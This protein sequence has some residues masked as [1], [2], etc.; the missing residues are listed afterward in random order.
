MWLFGSFSKKRVILFSLLSVFVGLTS[1]VSLSLAPYLLLTPILLCLLYSGG[2]LLPVLTGAVFSCASFSFFGGPLSA[3]LA[4]LA[5]VLPALL[6][7]IAIQQEVSYPT[8]LRI[9][10]AGH[11]GGMLLMLLLASALTGGQLI[12]MLVVAMR[13]AISSMPENLQDALLI[14]QYPKLSPSGTLITLTD[15]V[16]AEYLNDFFQQLSNQLSL[17]TLPQLTRSS[18]I[19]A[20]LS[21]YLPARALFRRGEL[22]RPS[23]QPLSEFHLSPQ[24]TVGVLLTTLAAYLL[25]LTGTAGADTAFLTMYVIIEV[26]FSAQGIAAMDR[27]LCASHRRTVHRVLLVSAVWLLVPELVAAAG[28]ASA[29]FGRSG[30]IRQFR[31]NGSSDSDR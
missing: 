19:S 7:V 6:T 15:A 20:G 22:I 5:L 26:V 30:L 10:V 13:Y 25:N 27:M 12:A 24:L 29:L 17:Q 28:L 23:F 2:G 8:Q 1:F 18:L 3:L 16:R 14:V 4:F 11:V 9:S 21:S 31:K